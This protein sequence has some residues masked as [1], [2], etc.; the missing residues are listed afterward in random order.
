M[1]MPR[2]RKNDSAWGWVIGLGIG[3][4]GY[5]LLKNEEVDAFPGKEPNPD[6]KR[7]EKLHIQEGP[8]EPDLKP[9]KIGATS[10]PLTA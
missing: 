3:L 5:Q 7:N 8:S 6:R 4:I 2:R 1:Y 10:F 9:K